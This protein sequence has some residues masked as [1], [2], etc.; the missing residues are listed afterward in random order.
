MV[1]GFWALDPATLATKGGGNN[2]PPN[3]GFG[4]D[5]WV[6]GNVA[7]SGNWGNGTGAEI[8]IWSLDANGIPTL[9]N[10]LIISRATTMSD[11]AVSPNGRMLV[12]T[13]E[14]GTRNGLY[15]WDRTD[16]IHP[17]QVAYY[18]VAEGLHTAETKEVNGRTY[19]FAA[20]DPSK[21]ALMI[22]DIT[23]VVH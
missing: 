16:P 18:P 7:Y 21:Q 12:G 19:V 15:V 14:G 4:S 6:V 13:V 11:V 5:L 22:F 10:T 9:A 2:L 8:A 20:R 1:S 17:V 23:D 3:F